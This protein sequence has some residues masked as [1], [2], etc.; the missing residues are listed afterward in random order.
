[1]KKQ[2]A[3][4]KTIPQKNSN[5]SILIVQKNKKAFFEYEVLDKYECGI[6]LLGAEV[7]SIRE[8]KVQF[9]DS[10]AKVHNTK[11]LL[12][13]MHISPY[14]FHTHESIDPIRIRTLLLHKEEI[15]KIKKQIEEKGR[16]L[17]PLAVYLKNGLIKIELGIGRGKNIHDKKEHLKAKTAQREA[18]KEIKS[19]FKQ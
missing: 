13:N 14:K 4:Q 2:H 12:H 1:M 9:T 16:T 18:E 15:K 5:A 10:F 7:K 8:K 11:V 17:I 3:P 6:M 19:Y